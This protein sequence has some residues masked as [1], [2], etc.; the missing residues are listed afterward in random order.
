[1]PCIGASLPATPIQVIFALLNAAIIFT[2]SCSFSTS[3]TLL[4][5]LKTINGLKAPFVQIIQ[6]S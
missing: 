5:A 4:N 2:L 3:P 1:M 6:D